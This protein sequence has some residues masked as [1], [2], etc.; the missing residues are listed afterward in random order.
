MEYNIKLIS[1]IQYFNYITYYAIPPNQSK[2]NIFILL[3]FNR[4]YFKT[5]L[6][7]ISIISNENKETFIILFYFLKNK[8]TFYP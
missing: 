4:D 2:Y 6:W 5:I 3:A 8:Y 1:N 7:N